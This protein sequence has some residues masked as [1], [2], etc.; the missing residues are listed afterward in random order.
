MSLVRGK[1]F[2]VSPFLARNKSEVY[3]KFVFPTITFRCYQ[4]DRCY[5]FPDSP[6]PRKCWGRP[7]GVFPWS[8]AMEI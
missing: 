2:I 3:K 6:W 7:S 4:S 1:D 8:E 5:R